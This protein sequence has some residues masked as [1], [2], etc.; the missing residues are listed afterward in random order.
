MIFPQ[1]S[2]RVPP[3]LEPPLRSNALKL[4]Q[5]L[6]SIGGMKSWSPAFK[7]HM[8]SK[9]AGR[10]YPD[11]YLVSARDIINLLSKVDW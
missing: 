1:A 5:D 7:A 8:V 11:C 3:P 6:R 10:A 4:H 2:P 9:L